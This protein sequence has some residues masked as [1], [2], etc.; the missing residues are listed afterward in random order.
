MKLKPNVYWLLGDQIKHIWCFNSSPAKESIPSNSHYWLFHILAGMR[1]QMK[2]S[3][4]PNCSIFSSSDILHWHFLLWCRSLFERSFWKSKWAL[5]S[6][7]PGLASLCDPGLLYANQKRNRKC[8]FLSVSASLTVL[9]FK[10]TLGRNKTTWK[11]KVLLWLPQDA[12][13]SVLVPVSF[14]KYL[15]DELFSWCKTRISSCLRP[16]CISFM[17]IMIRIKKRSNSSLAERQPSSLWFNR[18]VW[19]SKWVSKCNI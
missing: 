19:L 11:I 9:Q 13:R 4:S 3:E 14:S 2:A 10:G 15:D 17:R 6:Q 1:L 12:V 7:I 5:A 8:F 16:L 18:C